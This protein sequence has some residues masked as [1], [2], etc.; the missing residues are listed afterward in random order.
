[1]ARAAGGFAFVGSSFV[2]AVSGQGVSPGD[3]MIFFYGKELEAEGLS[4]WDVQEASAVR[5]D[6]WHYLSSAKAEAELKAAHKKSWYYAV[7]MQGDDLFAALQTPDEVSRPDSPG[8]RWF[9]KEAIYDPLPALE[10]LRVPT[11]F[12]FGDHDR[13]VP[14]NESVAIIRRVQANDTCHA[15]TIRVFGN[16][17]HGMNSLTG[18][19]SGELSPEYLETMKEWLTSHVPGVG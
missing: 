17:D 10:A 16:V 14:V 13:L 11:L 19:G 5:R 1:M 15:F 7:K 18:G 6:V 8:A 4:E 12:V 9:R 3:Q 2:I